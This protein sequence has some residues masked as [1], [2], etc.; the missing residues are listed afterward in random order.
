[1]FG[2]IV[3]TIFVIV[4]F[5]INPVLGSFI[6]ILVALGGIF[7]LLEM[8]FPIFKV[9]GDHENRL[10]DRHAIEQTLG[11]RIGKRCRKSLDSLVGF[12]ER[13]GR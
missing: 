5:L 4:C 7:S 9:R 1:M 10:R 8:A 3:A 13:V 11:Y 6:I 2:L 12:I